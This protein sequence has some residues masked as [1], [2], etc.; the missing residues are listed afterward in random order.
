MTCSP[1][2]RRCGSEAA[3]Q[4]GTPLQNRQ[5]EHAAA[6]AA[7]R[8]LIRP[9]AAPPLTAFLARLEQQQVLIPGD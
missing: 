7:V 5:A 1:G 8:T 9:A 2:T 3:I 6:V 4:P